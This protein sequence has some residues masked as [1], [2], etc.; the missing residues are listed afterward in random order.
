M[1]AAFST[2]CWA[3]DLNEQGSC[4]YTRE[5][6][7]EIVKL[8]RAGVCRPSQMFPDREDRHRYRA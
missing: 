4:V 3:A 8:R 1:V 2:W 6:C 5:Q 7:F